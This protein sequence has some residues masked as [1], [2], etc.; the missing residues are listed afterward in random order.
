MDIC[1]QSTSPKIEFRGSSKNADG[2]DFFL[3]FR[4]SQNRVRAMIDERIVGPPR[5]TDQ[6]EAL[7]GFGTGSTA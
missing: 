6:Y 3:L 5:S 2:I 1:E 4:R 7:A